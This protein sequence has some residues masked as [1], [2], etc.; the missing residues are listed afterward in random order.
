[1][2]LTVIAER[3]EHE[4]QL[5]A[6]KHLGCPL[7]QGFHFA[8]PGPPS[9]LR[10]DGFQPRG[11]PGYGDPYVIREFMRQIGIPARLDG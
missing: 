2:G 9:E 1:M 8:P 10:L 4:D 3:I 6:L 7:G 5:G 11:R